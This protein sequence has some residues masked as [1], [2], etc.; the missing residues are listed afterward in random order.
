MADRSAD[1]ARPSVLFV[2]RRRWFGIHSTIGVIAGGLLLLISWSGALAV[3]KNEFDWLV[4][5]ALRV[6]PSSHTQSF[7]A[8][9]SSVEHEFPRATLD[10]LQVAYGPRFAMIA[11]ITTRNDETRQVFVDPRTARVTGSRRS[12]ENLGS[13][14]NLL[15][16]FHVRLLMGVWGRMFVGCVGAILALTSC[17]GLFMMRQR[18]AT[19]R[20]P[21]LR[22]SGRAYWSSLHRSM[23]LW[24]L[25]FTLFMGV[26]G[27]IFGLEGFAPFVR[28]WNQRRIQRAHA[29]QLLRAPPAAVGPTRTA[30]AERTVN[31]DDAVRIA[32]AALP[33][34]SLRSVV[35]PTGDA[36][37]EYRVFLDNGS[38]FVRREASWV[39]V[40]PRTGR[41]VQRSNAQHAR[42]LSRAYDTLDPL[43]FGYV[44]SRFGAVPE[45]AVRLSWSVL[46]LV[47]GILAISGATMWW[48]RRKS[49]R[50]AR[51]FPSV[52]LAA[53]VAWLACGWLAMLAIAFRL[54]IQASPKIL[55]LGIG[56]VIEQLVAKPLTLALIAAPITLALAL[57]GRWLVRSARSVAL[58][59]AAWALAGL[60]MGTW[61]LALSTM[62]LH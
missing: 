27:A 47:P 52:S 46:G 28:R 21:P 61:Q 22:G 56:E 32:L 51:S 8:V 31:V 44:G 18:L 43:H 25:L 62:F 35:L 14:S 7:A 30:A 58:S 16:Q 15:R 60:S 23:A 11:T 4:T 13:I 5:P 41:V 24:S 33:G 34:M 1:T 3:F 39:D 37:S 20:T 53:G 19:L 59:R 26:S 54:L 6:R 40:G 12:D 36:D 48:K 9:R 57:V 29:T 55:G 49:A 17:I 42:W 50:G 10:D 45:Y 2:S 38:A